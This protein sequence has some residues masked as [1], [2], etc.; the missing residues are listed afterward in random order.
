VA[1]KISNL[2]ERIQNTLQHKATEE[3]DHSSAQS[4]SRSSGQFIPLDAK[5]IVERCS[6]IPIPAELLVPKFSE[7]YTSFD[8]ISSDLFSNLS[9]VSRIV[10]Y[11]HVVG[12]F[13][14]AQ[15][16]CLQGLQYFRQQGLELLKHQQELVFP[17]VSEV[18][19]RFDGKPRVPAAEFP[20]TV[21]LSLLRWRTQS[22]DF[23]RYMQPY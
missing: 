4:A 22:V 13:E 3:T 16:F 18:V 23:G 12:N 20:S 19:E 15:G 7:H 11:K 9:L 1:A 21:S 10:Q 6:A 8:D 14:E 2:T 5:L 17:V